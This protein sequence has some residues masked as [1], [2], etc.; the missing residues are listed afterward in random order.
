MARLAS[1]GRHGFAQSLFSVGGNAGSAVGPLLAAWIVLPNGQ[2]SIAW[3]ALVA[4]LAIAILS[5]VSAW[6]DHHHGPRKTL[7]ASAGQMASPVLA[8]CPVGSASAASCPAIPA[9]P[10]PRPAATAERS[11]RT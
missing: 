7:R 1:G 10:A 8:H 4:L 2:R 9:T 11:I 6:Y 3:F 5:R